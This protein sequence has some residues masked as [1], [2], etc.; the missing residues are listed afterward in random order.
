MDFSYGKNRGNRSCRYFFGM[1]NCF[2]CF[3]V[4]IQ[5]SMDSQYSSF[6]RL[7]QSDVEVKPEPSIAGDLDPG[8]H[9]D[10]KRKTPE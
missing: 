4:I 9:R 8:F 7:V 1:L 5:V 6:R 2:D 3:L 10:D